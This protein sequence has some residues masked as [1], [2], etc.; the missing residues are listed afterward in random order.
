[1]QS[2]II[3]SA[4]LHAIF[5]M[6][7][8]VIMQIGMLFYYNLKMSKFLYQEK[9]HGPASKQNRPVPSFLF[10][11]QPS[12]VY[13]PSEREGHGQDWEMIR[14]LYNFIFERVE[15]LNR[16]LQ[17]IIVDHA[18]IEDDSFNMAIIED[19]HTDDNLIPDDWYSENLFQ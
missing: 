16:Q 14:E 13:F 15:N 11:D 10:I 5:L 3:A 7:W 2:L 1:V 17:V 19:W 9:T 18:N 12:Q 4:E 6:V 8:F